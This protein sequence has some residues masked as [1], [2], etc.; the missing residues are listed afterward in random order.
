MFVCLLWLCLL[1]FGLLLCD[2]KFF[3]CRVI[4]MLC[5][6]SSLSCR[7]GCLFGGI[8][9]MLLLYILAGFGG[10]EFYKMRPVLLFF[11]DFWRISA[12]FGLKTACFCA[13][14]ADFCGFMVV[15]VCFVVVM[16]R[17][18]GGLLV[19]FE[20]GFCEILRK[21]FKVLYL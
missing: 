19:G 3:V 9:A 18:F 16:G 1:L 17:F 13:K 10:I 5:R 11:C 14:M 20:C 21:V 8:C 2:E 4:V 15:F 6:V 7:G 12:V